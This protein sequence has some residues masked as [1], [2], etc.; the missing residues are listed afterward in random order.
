MFRKD[1]IKL[2]TSFKT[3]KKKEKPKRIKADFKK[4]SSG[5]SFVMKGSTNKTVLGGKAKS[6]KNGSFFSRLKWWHI[7]LA[8]LGVIVITVAIVAAILIGKANS[9]V[10]GGEGGVE[11][12]PVIEGAVSSVGAFLADSAQE[13]ILCE[14][15]ELFSGE[16]VVFLQKASD[17]RY[18]YKAHYV[19]INEA[20]EPNY[21]YS[22]VFSGNY[23]P[24]QIKDDL[25]SLLKSVFNYSDETLAKCDMVVYDPVSFTRVTIS[26][27]I[28]AEDGTASIK[29]K[30]GAVDGE[31]SEEYELIGT[32]T[33]TENDFAFTYTNLPEDE[34]LLRVAENILVSAKYEYYVY[35]NQ[36]VNKLT[37]GDSYAL[38][39]QAEAAEG[40]E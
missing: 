22:G 5:K 2:N 26:S 21:H 32:Y 9:M 27:A 35:S 29:Y 6:E 4:P 8:V 34:N 38:Y 39:L 36:Y 24:E 11:E 1:K 19:F 20:G 14:Y 12:P 33:K 30:A 7:L 28:I 10:P 15:T 37:F 16:K 18:D 25:F 31:M 17:V 23:T 13:Y 3:T 40:A